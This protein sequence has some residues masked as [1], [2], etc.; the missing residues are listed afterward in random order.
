LV[1]AAAC[2]FRKDEFL[3]CVLSLK[4]AKQNKIFLQVEKSTWFGD[5]L[6]KK[7]KHTTRMSF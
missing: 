2:F 1:L 5:Y 4:M 3:A 7:L 6:L